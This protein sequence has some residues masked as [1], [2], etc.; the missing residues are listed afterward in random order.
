MARSVSIQLSRLL[1]KL[2]II[3]AGMMPTTLKA[4]FVSAVL[5]AD[6]QV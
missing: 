2:P 1:G 3:I 5:E 6:Y 4:D